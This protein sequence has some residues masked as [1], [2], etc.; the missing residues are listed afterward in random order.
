MS[1]QITEKDFKEFVEVN[2]KY[3]KLGFE[4]LSVTDLE[5]SFA[6]KVN[7]MIAE[8]NLSKEQWFKIMKHYKIFYDSWIDR[9]TNSN[10]G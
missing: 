1:V 9:E 5:A 7:T 3:Q 6:Y 4:I 10:E 8:T 2:N